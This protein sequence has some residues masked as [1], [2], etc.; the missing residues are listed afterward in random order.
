MSDFNKPARVFWSYAQV[1]TQ[2]AGGGGNLSCR[3][4]PASTSAM[5]VLNGAVV[6]SGTRAVSIQVYNADG[7]YMSSLQTIAAVAGAR[8]SVP[9][10]GSASGVTDGNIVGQGLVIAAPCYLLSFVALAGNTETATV[11]M[12][13]ELFG[14]RTAPTIVWTDSG[15]TPSPAAATENTITIVP[16]EY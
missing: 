4:T 12:N 3:I 8:A 5:K 15:G 16:G 1:C 14:T 2:T 10:P 7:L 6:A 13:C 11:M 9:Q